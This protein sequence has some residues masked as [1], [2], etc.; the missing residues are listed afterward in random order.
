MRH[1]EVASV[2]TY[3][4]QSGQETVHMLPTKLK[5]SIWVSSVLV[6][7]LFYSDFFWLRYQI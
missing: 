7:Y 3:L 4:L 6:V 2:G 5:D 1:N